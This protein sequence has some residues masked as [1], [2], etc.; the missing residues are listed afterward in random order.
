MAFV[1]FFWGK[2]FFDWG[3]QLCRATRPLK[4]LGVYKE[5]AENNALVVGDKTPLTYE[6][7]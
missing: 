7:A 1:R 5:E 2:E 6:L 3:G 4:G